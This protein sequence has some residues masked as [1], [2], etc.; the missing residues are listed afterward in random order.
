V[1]YGEL[2]M[3]ECIKTFYPV[4][5]LCILVL[6]LLYVMFR[7][8]KNYIGNVY[9]LLCIRDRSRLRSFISGYLKF[10]L[11]AVLISVSAGLLLLVIMSLFFSPNSSNE[12]KRFTVEKSREGY[13]VTIE[14][15]VLFAGKRGLNVRIVALS[16]SPRIM[17]MDTDGCSHIYG[18]RHIKGGGERVFSNRDVYPEYE[19]ISKVGIIYYIKHLL[20]LAGMRAGFA[21][22]PT[23]LLQPG[24]YEYRLT[25]HGYIFIG[26]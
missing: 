6:Y 18:L 24:E 2:I 5:L 10:V 9:F 15:E 1:V 21:E 19:F 23:F 11:L 22:S 13:W 17:I 25:K 14:G 26:S 8:V 16:A 7:H 12:R 20:P 4:Y 3:F